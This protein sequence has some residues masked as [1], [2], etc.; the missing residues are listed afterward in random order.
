MNT[1]PSSLITIS[2]PIITTIPVT[3]APLPKIFLGIYL[4]YIYIPLSTLFF[5]DST[6]STT[7]KVNTP[8]VTVNIS[9]IGAGVDFCVTKGP[10]TSTASPFREDDPDIILGMIKKL[11]KISL[12]APLTFIR[13]TMV[14]MLKW[15]KGNLNTLVPSWIEFWSLLSFLPTMS[16]CW[17]DT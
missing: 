9:Y 14:M 11:F 16:S 5:M 8:E 12:S 2:P 7:T 1:P 3:I 4:P 13:T 6:A 10:G 15:L 17:S